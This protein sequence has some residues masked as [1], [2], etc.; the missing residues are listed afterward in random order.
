MSAPPTRMCTRIH[1]SFSNVD[2]DQWTQW[3]A[4]P[5]DPGTGHKAGDRPDQEGPG[6]DERSQRV[7][8][9]PALRHRSGAGRE[10]SAGLRPQVID[11][12]ASRS[13]R[14]AGS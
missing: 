2:K 9:L 8:R 10:C 5:S 4:R 7:H 1:W 3:A 6:D 14:D 11:F 12:D 13:S